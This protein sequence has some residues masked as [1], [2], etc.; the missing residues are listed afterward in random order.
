MTNE[1]CPACGTGR[2]VPIAYGYPHFTEELKLALEEGRFILGGC[3]VREEKQACLS[4]G[5]RH[6][7]VPPPTLPAA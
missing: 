5:A 7:Q 3:E 4:C 1:L 2:L 6:R